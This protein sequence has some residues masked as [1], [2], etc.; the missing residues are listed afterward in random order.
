MLFVRNVCR[1]VHRSYAHR[2]SS[3]HRSQV[4]TTGEGGGLLL[5]LRVELA[6][7]EAQRVQPL[8]GRDVA[9]F[10][11]KQDWP[12]SSR[13]P[14][15]RPPT[16]A[17]LPHHSTGISTF[18]SS[19]TS[20][21]RKQGCVQTGHGRSSDEA[22]VTFQTL[23][24][25]DPAEEAPLRLTPD[26]WMEGDAEAWSVRSILQFDL[27]G[28]NWKKFKVLKYLNFVMVFSFY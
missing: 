16:A 23:E 21:G 5:T 24:N 8:W 14:S 20:A 2:S 26:L 19:L 6:S 4:Q 9:S 7:H 15:K 3:S 13:P 25:S 18:L 17:A 27:H 10:T 11:V 22:W 28:Q 12:S 1:C